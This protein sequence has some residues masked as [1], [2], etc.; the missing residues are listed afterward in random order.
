M[1]VFAL[2]VCPLMTNGKE[3]S[4]GTRLPFR[5]FTV[6]CLLTTFYICIGELMSGY[7]CVQIELFIYGRRQLLGM[8]KVSFNDASRSVLK[9]S[10][11]F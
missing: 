7:V 2:G 5:G 3:L 1:Y 10:P 9:L 6:C 11:H 8:L 4:T